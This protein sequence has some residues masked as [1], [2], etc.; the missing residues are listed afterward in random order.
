M[1][2]PSDNPQRKTTLVIAPVALLQQWEKEF[3][4][5]VVPDH[6]LSIYVHHGLTRKNYTFEQLNRFDVVITS[7][8]VI[9]NE[10]KEHFTKVKDRDNPNIEKIAGN[11][12]FFQNQS[13]WY[14]IILDEAHRIKNGKTGTAIS[15]TRLEAEYRWCLSGTPMQNNVNELQSLIRFLRIKPYDDPRFFSIHIGKPLEKGLKKNGQEALKKLRYLLKS[16]M[17]RRTKNTLID[18]KPILQLPPKTITMESYSFDPDEQ[19]YYE[20]L[21]NGAIIR[22]NKYLSDNSIKK[23]YSSI[24]V[25]LL[26]LRQACDHPKIVERA[27]LIKD[28]ELLTS[29]TSVSAVRCARNLN[30]QVVQRIKQ[31]AAFQCPM[32]MDACDR[33]DVVLISP[34]GH[35]ICSDCCT[36]S[37]QTSSDEVQSSF[38]CP[39]CNI[40]ISE[41]SFFDFIVFK[42][43]YIQNLSDSQIAS[44]RKMYRSQNPEEKSQLASVDSSQVYNSVL[45]NE[46]SKYPDNDDESDIS[47]NIDSDDDED[48]FAPKASHKKETPQ[49][50]MLSETEN[51]NDVKPEL[52]S[53]IP[54]VKSD[55][56]IPEIKLSLKNRYKKKSKIEEHQNSLGPLLIHEELRQLFPDGWISS[57]KITKCIELIKSIRLNYPGQKILV[58]S[59]FMSMLD[60]LEVALDLESQNVV[61]GR[62]D[63][64]MSSELRAK[65]IDDF[66]WKPDPSVL[67]ISLK[68]GNVGLTL[69]AACHVIIMDPFWNPFVEEQAMDRAYRIGQKFPVNVHRLIIANSVEDRILKLQEKKRDL[70]DAALDEKQMKGMS[71]LDERE[72]LYLFGLNE[73]GQRTQNLEIPQ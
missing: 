19:E 5:H 51:L 39:S 59:Q 62:Y 1:T 2:H 30:K 72:L 28:K 14:R 35:H 34:C 3:E 60:F 6:R 16:I 8:G 38:R 54:V 49:K 68:A 42:W 55:P 37:F 12:P 40:A 61:Y 10:H 20:Y 21:E 65:T 23:N 73:R 53:E 31:E 71:R 45:E 66:T 41:K 11:S 15:C 47:S 57:T 17:L 4:K 29:R 69:T 58:F 24:L 25:L 18:N 7:Y 43:I 36:E 48:I 22:M 13:Q 9:M 52:K 44:Y 56:D 50:H 64:S 27:Y 63:G 46:T 67:L 26:R 70:I 33:S 32:C